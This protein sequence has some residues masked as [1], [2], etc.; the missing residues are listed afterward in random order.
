MPITVFIR[1]RIDPY[2]RQQFEAYARRFPDARVIVLPG[3]SYHIAAVEPELCARHARDFIAQV[4][5]RSAAS[6]SRAAE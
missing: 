5:W 3:D 4:S 1:Y 2:K 6:G